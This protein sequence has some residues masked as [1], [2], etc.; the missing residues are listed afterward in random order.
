MRIV[1]V[2]PFYSPLGGGVRTYI[3]SKFAAAPSLGHEVIVLAP[4][5]R[6]KVTE[7]RPGALLVTITSPLFPLDRRYRYFDDE[8]RLHRELGLW[9]PDHVEA[10]SPW[11][12]AS[13]VGRWRGPATRSLVLHSDPLSAYA[14]RWLDP[15]LNRRAIDFLFGWFWTHLRSLDRMFD[16]VVAPSRDYTRRLLLGGVTKARTLSLGVEPGR[17]DPSLRD[18]QLRARLLASVGLGE[19]ATLLVGLGRFAPEKRWEMVIKAAAEA[20][21]ETP[22]GLVLA[23]DGLRRPQV[24]RAAARHS[25]IRILDPISDRPGIARLLASADA[26]VHGCETETFGL[27]VS[28]ARASGIPLIVPNRGGAAAQLARGAGLAYRAGNERSLKR[29]ILAFV[30]RDPEAQRRRAT[31]CSPVRTMDDHFRELFDCYRQV[32]RSSEDWTETWP[33]AAAR[34]AAVPVPF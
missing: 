29:A 32:E 8:T 4:G 18:E 1:D 28:E 15:F 14:Y 23:G 9:R 13:M 34:S 3:E 17:F 22:I 10:S 7:I 16:A 26:L 2:C 5:E 25:N 20:A 27:V 6:D 21:E 33:V 31:L 19:S 24:E 11:S 12:S 30:E